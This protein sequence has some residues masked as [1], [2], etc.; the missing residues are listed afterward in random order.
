MRSLRSASSRP[1]RHTNPPRVAG[2]P[3]RAGEPHRNGPKWVR[4]FA[5][6]AIAGLG[7]A[8]FYVA[9]DQWVRDHGGPEFTVVAKHLANSSC[10]GGWVIPGSATELGDIPPDGDPAR[11][12]WASENGAVDASHTTAEVTVQGTSAKA[13]IL[14]G[15]TVDATYRGEPMM[16]IHVVEECGGPLEGRFFDIDLDQSPPLLGPSVDTRATLSGTTPTPEPELINFPYTVRF[17]HQLSWGG[18]TL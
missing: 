17:S 11:D 12:Q 16:G 15:I 14:T 8:A 9:V 18:M 4:R 5:A 13:V 1:R 2:T 6:I 10:S 3:R 7:A